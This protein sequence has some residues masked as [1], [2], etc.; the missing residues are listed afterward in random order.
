MQ[1][2]YFTAHCPRCHDWYPSED[3][4]THE[5]THCR[6]RPWARWGEPPSVLVDQQL[7]EQLAEAACK[8]Q[9]T[10]LISVRQD[11]RGKL[12]SPHP[13]VSHRAF[14]STVRDAMVNGEDLDLLLADALSLDSWEELVV[15]Y[16]VE[17]V[18]C[19]YCGESVRAEGLHK[20]QSQ[21]NRCH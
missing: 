7:T 4:S 21:S 9:V 5:S 15:Q 11:G 16:P 13:N 12:R 19:P 2:R 8:L 6:K 18:T 10:N 14:V 20:H 1:A 3:A 17:I